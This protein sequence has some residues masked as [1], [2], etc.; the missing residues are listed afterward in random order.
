MIDEKN[1]KI[2]MNYIAGIQG[3]LA[4]LHF[5]IEENE[6]QYPPSSKI[7]SHP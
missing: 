7:S 1:Q 5:Q 3:E 2:Q 4:L 6:H